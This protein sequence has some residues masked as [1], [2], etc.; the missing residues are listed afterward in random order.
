MLNKLVSKITGLYLHNLPFYP[1]RSY[2]DFNTRIFDDININRIKHEFAK[3]CIMYDIPLIVNNTSNLIN[4]HCF[5][6]FSF[7]VKKHFF[8]KITKNSVQYQNV[9]YVNN[10]ISCTSLVCYSV[11]LDYV[12]L[13][14]HF[15]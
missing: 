7:Y 10:S 14:K 13:H 12:I 2:H 8:Y 3:R 1:N 15:L 4:T 11:I 6:G 9:I 5:H